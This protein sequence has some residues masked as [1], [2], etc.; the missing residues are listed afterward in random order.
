MAQAPR[1]RSVDFLTPEQLQRKREVDR[2]SQRQVR[3]RTKAYISELEDELK[4]IKKRNRS[5][6]EE[7][8][9]WREQWACRSPTNASLRESEDERGEGMIQQECPLPYASEPLWSSVGD[10]NLP[11]DQTHSSLRR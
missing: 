5:L 8:I 2:K 1:L 10:L 11:L 4:D 6:E 3:E 9:V 7:L